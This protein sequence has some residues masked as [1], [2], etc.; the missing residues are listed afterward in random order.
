MTRT[1]ATVLVLCWL[2]A[3]GG[4]ASGPHGGLPGGT[5]GGAGNG[6]SSPR[7]DAS[8]SDAADGASLGGAPDGS[9]ASGGGSAGNGAT[10]GSLAGNGGS[11][12]G[13]AGNG[14]SGAGAGVAG[15]GPGGGGGTGSADPGLSLLPSNCEARARMETSVTCQ[16]SAVCDSIANV[17]SCQV[18]D[19]GRWQC[20]SQPHHADRVYEIEGAAGLQACAV[21]TGIN[22]KETLQVG[23]DACQPVTDS[24]GDGYCAMDMV[25]GPFIEVDFAPGVRARLARYG[26]V[27]CT[28]QPSAPAIQCGFRFHDTAKA[29]ELTVDSSSFACRSLLEF[30]MST[31]GPDFT[32]P[33][34][35]V[36]AQETADGQG[37]KRSD[38]CSNPL[39]SPEKVGMI[40]VEQRSAECEP[41]KDGAGGADCSCSRRDLFFQFHVAS[42]PDEPTCAAAV[43]SCEETAIIKGTGDATCQQQSQ[44]TNPDNCE[45]DLSCTQDATVDGREVVSDG[46]LFV[47]CARQDGRHPWSCSCASD[48]LTATFALGTSG[49]TSQQACR[50]APQ[51]CLKHIPVHLGPYTS[52]AS[53]PD[54]VL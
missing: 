45:A 21:A 23:K 51:E 17:T 4:R 44:T 41:G 25:C 34:T 12:G 49:A 33:R 37:C 27:A 38:L 8:A 30:S 22:A 9:D 36:V 35:C 20:T 6:G 52:F 48:Q 13:L 46:R 14:A 19:S 2:A 47:K 16:L 29:Y 26:Y 1:S 24:S 53:A 10:S 43:T 11:N 28:E 15:S 54:P 31:S 39:S 18:L 7:P 5:G 32:G 40:N 50:Q 42:M 3:C